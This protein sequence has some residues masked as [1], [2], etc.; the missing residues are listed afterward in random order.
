MKSSATKQ[1][2]QEGLQKN[3]RKWS[4]TLMDAGYMTIPN[5][6][7]EH[8][9]ALGLDAVDINVL[10]HLIRHWWIADNLP[11]PSKRTMADCM[12]VDVSTIRRHIK[13][14]EDRGLVR[15]VRRFDKTHGQ[16]SNR[17]DLSG[18]IEQAQPLAEEA[19][20]LKE[21]RREEDSKRRIRRVRTPRVAA[22]D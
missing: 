5:V 22:M 18:L 2:S 20:K 8:Q 12:S 21:Q 15:R 11:Y 17:S 16:K 13:A 14:M 6:I 9:R 10:L 4:P 19:L 3:E 1:Q 7:V